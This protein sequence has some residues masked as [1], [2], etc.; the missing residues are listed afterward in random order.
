M[1]ITRINEV[2]VEA[3]AGTECG[4]D[5]VLQSSDPKASLADG[6][7]SQAINWNP[8]ACIPFNLPIGS[9]VTLSMVAFTYLSSLTAFVGYYSCSVRFISGLKCQSSRT[10]GSDK[11]LIAS[12]LIGIDVS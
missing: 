9:Q 10:L 4:K 7:S 1:M 5:L 3:S 2:T 12:Y 11:A 8:V 6:L